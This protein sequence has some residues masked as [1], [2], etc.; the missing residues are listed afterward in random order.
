M[1]SYRVANLFASARHICLVVYACVDTGLQRSCRH[2]L[3]THAYSARLV[4]V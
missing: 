2:L 4:S 3:C 1:R